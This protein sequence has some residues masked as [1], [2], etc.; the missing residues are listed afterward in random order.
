MQKQSIGHGKQD[1][2]EA[3][4]GRLTVHSLIVQSVIVVIVRG[5]L[6]M[7]IGK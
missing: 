2:Q 7:S 4:K 1:K 3:E 5:A 6:L